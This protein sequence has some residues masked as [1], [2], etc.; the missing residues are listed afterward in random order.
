MI[1]RMF[2]RIIIQSQKVI[3]AESPIN[4]GFLAEAMIFY[5]NVEVVG[6][7]AMIDQLVREIGPDVLLEFLKRDYRYARRPR[8]PPG[9]PTSNKNPD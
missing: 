4:L 8:S 2:E 9:A 6:S 3:D 5:G 7:R 1:E